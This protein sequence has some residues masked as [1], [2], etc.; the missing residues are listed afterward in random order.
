MID[1][2]ISEVVGIVNDILGSPRRDAAMDGWTEYNCPCCAEENGGKP[3][4]KYNFCINYSK[5]VGH[6]WKC[7]TSGKI[8][9]YIRRYGGSEKLNEYR[10]I[11]NEIRR[12]Q[13]YSLEK[14][15]ITND[16]EILKVENTLTLP[17]D[18]TNDFN[19]GDRQS[20]YA[21]SYLRKR[22]IGDD[23]IRRHN[24]GYVGWTKEPNMSF[25]I[26]V[27]SYDEFGE[28]N[29]FIARDYSGKND[30]RKYNNPNIPK[31]SY[32]FDEGM[33]NWYEDITL[34]E[35]VFDH[36]VVPNSIP[37]LG[38]IL[39]EKSAVF[40]ALVNR[41]MANVNVMLDGD[42]VK[43]AKKLYY[44]LE[45]SVLKDRVRIIICDDGYDAST[46]YEKFGIEG[47]KHL[48]KSKRKLNDFDR[49]FD[50]K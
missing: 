42:A 41:A 24:I 21:L 39:D 7:G 47:I 33:V 18:Y 46:I 40:S 49:I 2:N 27:P 9:K 5:G 22:G 50:I 30:K 14:Y 11:I 3:D 15:G 28:L 36:I 29:Y 45:D 38:K 17:K 48:M 6:C 31:T 8:S 19:N 35:G 25:R 37:L 16:A 23:I 10:R 32:I 13:Q 34:V 26:I 20:S 43:D 44:R 1:D 12:S 4:G